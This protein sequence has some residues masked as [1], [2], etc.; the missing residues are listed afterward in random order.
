MIQ[1]TRISIALALV[2]GGGVFL[3]GCG[4][5]YPLC[6]EDSDCHEGEFCI[7]GRCQQC[8][9]DSDCEAGQHCADGRCEEIPGYCSGPG[10]CPD[11]QE[12]RN[13]R[14]VVTATATETPT[15]SGPCSLQPAYFSFDSSDLDDGARN[16]LQADARCINERQIAAARVVGHTDPRGTEEY[17]L[18]LGDRRARAAQQ[19]MESLGV[20]CG[21]LQSSSGGEV[22][23]R[24]TDECGWSRDRRVEVQER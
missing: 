18:A 14:C 23:A 10:D 3:V 20:A 7:D 9:Q 12:C 8:R 11:G 24:G 2:F 1:S 16:T 13:N 6:G 4:P 19:Y 22:M 15:E 17:N 21:V 5:D